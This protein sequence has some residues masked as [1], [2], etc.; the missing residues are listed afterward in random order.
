MDPPPEL[1]YRRLNFPNA[2]PDEYDWTTN[3]ARLKQYGGIGIQ[4]MSVDSWLNLI[5]QETLRQDGHIGPTPDPLP[6]P[7]ERGGCDCP[8]CEQNRQLLLAR[9]TT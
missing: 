4:R 7:I 2:I 3:D 6:R 5:D 9:T 8:A 1:V